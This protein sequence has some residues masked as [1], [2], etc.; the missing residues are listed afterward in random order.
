[1]TDFN[2][3][4]PP[5]SGA[6]PGLLVPAG[7]WRRAKAMIVDILI[8]MLAALIPTVMVVVGLVTV[9]DEE[10]D[11]DTAWVGWILFAIGLVLWLVVMVWAGWKFGWRQGVTGVTPGKRRLGIRLVDVGTGEAPGGARGLG[12]WLVPGLINSVVNVF[13]LIDYLW[14]LWDDENQR[15]TDKMFKTWVVEA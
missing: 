14:P 3:V 13:S 1:M 7:W 9:V 15:V 6:E 11:Y 10:T 2:P 5:T 8:F 4:P 12:R